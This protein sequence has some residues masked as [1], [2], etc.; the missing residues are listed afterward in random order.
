MASSDRLILVRNLYSFEDTRQRHAA[1][2]ARG[3]EVRI[4]RGAY[5]DEPLGGAGRAGQVPSHDPGGGRDPW[6]PPHP[7]AL[8]GGGDPRPSH[9]RAWPHRVHVTQDA[10]IGT[11]SRGMVVR[12]SLPLT[13][14]DVVEIDG[15]LV[16]SVARTV[17]DLAVVSP[18]VSAV[19]SMDA[20]LHV[21]RF[22]RRP[23]L[24]T[25]DELRGPGMLN[26]RFEVI[27]EPATSST[28]A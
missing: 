22:Q 1:R 23:P 3:I 17:I 16:T 21:D 27:P 19:T 18:G 10:A 15:L 25:L 2:A 13:G 14:R 26:C 8:V 7:V 11:R 20:A 6:R 4:A 24:V 9:H 5:I 12:H 28:S